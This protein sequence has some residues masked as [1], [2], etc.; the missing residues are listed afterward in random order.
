M[1]CVAVECPVA[2]ALLGG[3]TH[4]AARAHAAAPLTCRDAVGAS[5]E[6][7]QHAAAGTDVGSR[8]WV[9]GGEQQAQGFETKGVIPEAPWTRNGFEGVIQAVTFSC[10]FDRK[11]VG[12][13]LRPPVSMLLRPPP[14]RAGRLG[15]ERARSTTPP[16]AAPQAGTA[17]GGRGWNARTGVRLPAPS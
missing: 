13:Y 12:V 14:A 9:C 5:R 6:R 3:G 8:V 2:G 10:F 7:R 11:W 16:S 15:T 4:A 17:A 1:A